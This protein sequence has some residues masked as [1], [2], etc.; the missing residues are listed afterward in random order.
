MQLKQKS[1]RPLRMPM[2]GTSSSQKWVIKESSHRLVEQ[3]ASYPEARNR[4]LLSPVL[5]WRSQRFCFWM[6]LPQPWI[7]SMK[8]L[9]KML[10]IDTELKLETWPPSLLHIDCLPSEMLTKLSFLRMVCSLKW[11][12]MRSS[13]LIT[14]MECMQASVPSKRMLKRNN[15]LK[16]LKLTTVLPKLVRLQKILRLLKWKRSVMELMKRLKSN[17]R[18]CKRRMQRP[19]DLISL[20]HT[21][22]QN[23]TWLWLLLRLL[24]MDRVNLYSEWLLPKS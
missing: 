21:T 18:N 17:R 22:C 23:T 12:T 15:L 10:L 20:C 4:E 1:F 16:R 13:S 24:L 5:S 8:E 14:Q 9:C 19:Q 2:L 11:V 6:R 3:V 7:R